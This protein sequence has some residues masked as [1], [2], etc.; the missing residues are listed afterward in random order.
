VPIAQ[1]SEY[2]SPADRAE[3]VLIRQATASRPRR[4]RTDSA[5]A[6][7]ITAATP[8]VGGTTY[9]RHI[10]WALIATAK[11]CPSRR[12]GLP[13]YGSALATWSDAAGTPPDA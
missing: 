8:I 5:V 4:V 12:H 10:A 13:C 3:P 1:T 11:L 2:T 7:S 9:V 6:I